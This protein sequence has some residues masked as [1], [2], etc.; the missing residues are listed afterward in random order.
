MNK[1]KLLHRISVL[2]FIVVITHYIPLKVYAEDITVD[3]IVDSTKVEVGEYVHYTVRISNKTNSN[4]PQPQFPSFQG[5]NVNQQPA[6]TRMETSIINSQMTINNYVEYPFILIATKP[7]KFPIE[8]VTI[9]YNG[10][11]YSSQPVTIE[12]IPTG[13]STGGTGSSEANQLSSVSGFT[14]DANIDKQLRGNLFIKADIDNKNPYVGQQVSLS[15]YLYSYFNL[16]G[17]IGL[18]KEPHFKD[19]ITEE[20]EIPNNLQ[21][22]EK[23]IDGKKFDIYFIRR[24]VLFPTKTGTFTINPYSLKVNLRTSNKRSRGPFDDFFND[25]FF[26]GNVIP[27]TVPSEPITITVKPLPEQNKPANFAGVV[28]EYTL[29]YSINKTNAE[30]GEPLSLKITLA[31]KGQLDAINE[32]KFPQLDGFELYGCEKK[33]DKQWDPSGYIVGKKTFNLVLRTNKPG[34]LTLPTIEYPIF[35]PAKNK[36]ETLS[37]QPITINVKAVAKTIPT[38]LVQSSSQAGTSAGQGAAIETVNV[39][40]RYIKNSGFDGK[41]KSLNLFDNWTFN[42]VQIIPILFAAGMFLINR[43]RERLESDLGYRRNIFAKGTANKR[44]A[45]AKKV[46]RQ[47]DEIFYGELSNALT[48]YLAD[49]FN[50]SAAGLTLDEIIKYLDTANVQNEIKDKIKGVLDQCDMARFAPVQSTL[51]EKQKVYAQTSNIIDSIEKIVKK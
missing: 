49:K 29:N 14:G 2:F 40:I 8:P 46:L 17:N 1:N 25:P 3:A 39:N 51:E 16:S 9:E 4:L 10:K 26:G 36:Y 33:A 32:P 45:D 30:E 5:F 21:K 28:G 13:A 22:R 27:A 24:L 50:V 19:F 42:A 48:H 47:K 18:V 34:K 44:L 7:G 20:Y 23:I 31:G 41:S 15:Y 11:T 38:E 37:T 35:D 12:V 6:S 43:R